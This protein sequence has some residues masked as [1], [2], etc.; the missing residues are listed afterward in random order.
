MALEGN[1]GDWHRA[2]RLSRRSE[3]RGSCFRHRGDRKSESQ[4]HQ[5]E[6]RKSHVRRGDR[7]VMKKASGVPEDQDLP[8]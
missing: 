4:S 5:A 7:V 6:E 1:G 3:W 8:C 2:G